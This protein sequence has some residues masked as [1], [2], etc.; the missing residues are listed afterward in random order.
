[1]HFYNLTII[2]IALGLDAFSIAFSVGLNK[3]TTKKKAVILIMVFGFFQFLFVTV[4]GCFG[5]LFNMYIF[6]L[7]SRLG[8]IIVFLVGMLMF[9]EGLSKEE[10]LSNLNFIIIM[11]LGICVSIDA[12]V[13]GFT[14]FSNFNIE[15]LI[16]RNSSVIGFICSLLTAIGLIISKKMRKSFFLK[17][18]ATLLGGIILILFGIKMA[19]C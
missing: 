1:M 15:T 3:K 11:L 2:S 5:G 8:G 19:L 13:I 6:H 16:V 18:Y 10:K 9:K 4:G 7:S 17:N 14:L 12:L